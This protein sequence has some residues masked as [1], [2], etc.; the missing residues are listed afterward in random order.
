VTVRSE[1]HAVDRMPP[2]AAT[3]PARGQ[4]V[5]ILLYHEITAEPLL[6]GH[7]AVGPEAFALQLGYLKGGGFSALRA[8]D[9][10]R[11]LSTGGALPERP[12]VLTFDDGF[13]DLYDRGLPLL[14]SHGVTATLFVTT[15]WIA[16]GSPRRAPAPGSTRLPDSGMLSW[17]QISELA[18]AGLEIGAHTLTHPQLDQLRPDAL[19]SE[20]VDCKHM[21]EDRLGMAVT[22]LSYPYG[23]SSRPVR[24]AAAAAGYSYACAVANKLA[25]GSDDQLSLPRVTIGKVTS[26]DAF[27][28]ILCAG[29]L[30]AEYLAYHALTRGFSVVR[31]V[32]PA[33][34]RVRGD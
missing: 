32:N 23:Y 5:P 24:A 31:R 6:P 10:A 13:A 33:L 3:A 21:L 16:D 22:G 19:R 20:L 28:R 4:R 26:A 25:R 2:S 7:L 9:L 12:V 1:R 18:A 15:G 17:S 8:A 29:R 30:P 27:A 11:L 14:T 34:N